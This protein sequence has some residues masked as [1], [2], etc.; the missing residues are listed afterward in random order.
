[1]LCKLCQKIRPPHHSQ[2]ISTK[3]SEEVQGHTCIVRHHA[4]FQDLIQSALDGCELCELFRP[5]IENAMKGPNEDEYNAYLNGPFQD[6]DENRLAI[7]LTEDIVY[8]DD[9]DC[10]VWLDERL[11]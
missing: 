8:E 1:M 2:R 11:D 3:H 6:H 7:R 4:N 5:F 10:Y 9:G